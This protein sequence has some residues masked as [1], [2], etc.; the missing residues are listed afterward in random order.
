MQTTFLSQLAEQITALHLPM[1]KSVVVLPNRR[2]RRML[3]QALAARAE[4]PIFAPAVFTINDF[5][6]KLS[7]LECQD[8]FA[9]LVHLYR[10]Y[11]E[12]AGDEAD[13]FSTALSWMPAFVDDM[14]EVDKQLDNAE[15]IL[16]DL[17]SAKQFEIGFG[18]DE[19]S[20]EQARKVA[21]FNMLAQ[22]YVSFKETLS[23]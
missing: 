13:D 6:D 17:A 11:K 5:I 22:L 8:K 10:T 20:A 2:A 12:L 23:R 14:S 18:Q 19:V 21:F 1:E 9:L 16:S 4:G 3:F 15:H 7:P